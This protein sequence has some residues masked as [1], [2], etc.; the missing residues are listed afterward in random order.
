MKKI[1]ISFLLLLFFFSCNRQKDTVLTII[2]PIIHVD[3]VS[4]EKFSISN[5]MDSYQL[6]PLETSKD[7]LIKEVNKICC[8][9]SLIF[10]LDR[11]GNNN[12]L[13]FDWNGKYIRTIGSVGSGPQEYISLYDF[14][15][16]E[17]SEFLYF[18]CNKN[19]VYKYD[20]KGNLVEKLKLNFFAVKIEYNKNKLYFTGTEPNKNNLVV[21]D[22][23]GQHILY[24]NFSNSVLGD[25]TRTLLHPFYKDTVNV[26]YQLYLSNCVYGIKSNNELYIKYKIDF[27]DKEY[28][29]DKETKSYSDEQFKE[30][31]SRKRSHIKYFVENK[32]YALFLFF[33]ENQPCL[34][35][36]DITN[37]TTKSYYWL[38]NNLIDDF[39]GIQMFPIIEYT[40]KNKFIAVLNSFDIIEQRLANKECFQSLNL[41]E[42]DNPILYILNTK[43]N[44][45]K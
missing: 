38:S 31:M 9:D 29:V 26:F 16:D 8:T 23:T 14:C 6:L 28:I 43:Q 36:Y 20:Y 4:N 39:T 5:I 11:F 32:D 3:Q 30:I 1:N 25:H 18:L 40:Y 2:Q 35:V 33:D 7:C 13:V 42:D 44:N 21:T 10:I 12:A 34:G 15:L 27:G 17:T 37:G 45:P 41:S 19:A 24:E 22:M